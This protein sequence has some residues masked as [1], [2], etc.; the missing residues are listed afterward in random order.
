M[1]DEPS[2]ATA[3]PPGAAPWCGRGM[4]RMIAVRNRVRRL[5]H[6]DAGADAVAQDGLQDIELIAR[7]IRMTIDDHAGQLLLRC[8]DDDCRRAM[9]QH[10]GRHVYGIRGAS[11]NTACSPVANGVA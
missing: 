1:R 3:S 8:P 9:R 7:R 6:V 10:G 4:A 5:A 2:A 11:R